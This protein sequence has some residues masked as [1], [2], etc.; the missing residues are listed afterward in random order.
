MVFKFMLFKGF[1]LLVD[2]PT[3]RS[4]EESHNFEFVKR[5]LI[6]IAIGTFEMTLKNFIK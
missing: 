6:P 3:E 5:F 1:F 4:D 2:I